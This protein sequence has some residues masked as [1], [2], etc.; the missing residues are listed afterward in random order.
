LSVP[1]RRVHNP[2][3]FRALFSDFRPSAGTQH[4]DPSSNPS[5]LPNVEE[6]MSQYRTSEIKIAGSVPK[7]SPAQYSITSCSTQLA[8]IVGLCDGH[9]HWQ[10]LGRARTETK[11]GTCFVLPDR[12]RD[13]GSFRRTC[14]K[15]LLGV[16]ASLDPL[17]I[18]TDPFRWAGHFSRMLRTRCNLHLL[19]PCR[20]I[21]MSGT[22]HRF[23]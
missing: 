8:V 2:N 14:G 22:M 20:E 11:G 23:G 5:C 6:I 17:C 10:A 18:K 7:D 16:R 12:S 3:A 9:A 15:W 13:P 19:P 4:H 21:L 1:R